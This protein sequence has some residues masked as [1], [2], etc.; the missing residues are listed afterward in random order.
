[1]I[2]SNQSLTGLQL[3]V[4]NKRKF[5]TKTYVVGTKK[6]CL[7]ETVPFGHPKPVLN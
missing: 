4:H 1:M 5:S 6:N 2:V 7:N 3:R